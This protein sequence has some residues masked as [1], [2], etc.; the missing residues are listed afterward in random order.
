MLI[1]ES[2]HKAT[3]SIFFTFCRVQRKLIMEKCNVLIHILI[4]VDI[5]EGEI[6]HYLLYFF[7][8]EW[9]KYASFVFFILIKAITEADI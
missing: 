4:Y 1:F 2:D 5:S 6:N 8:F 3:E 9:L 7:L